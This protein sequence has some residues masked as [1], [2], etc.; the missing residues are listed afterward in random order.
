MHSKAVI[1]SIMALGMGAASAP[2][3]YT[4]Y[5][6]LRLYGEPGCYEQNMGEL[7]I[8]DVNKCQT[9]GGDETIRSV[10]FE[11]NSVGCSCMWNTLTRRNRG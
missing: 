6:Q 5:A 8:Y 3:S 10:S 7:G 9:F 1:A 11:T 4:R 2:A